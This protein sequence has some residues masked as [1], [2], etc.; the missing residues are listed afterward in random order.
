[1]CIAATAQAQDV[2][3]FEE[4]AVDDSACEQAVKP[5][6][7]VIVQLEVW[8]VT[9]ADADDETK[10]LSRQP[11]ED[12]DEVASRLKQLRQK[13][14]VSHSQYM[15]TT[16]LD[17]Q[18]TVL[19]LGTRQPRIQGTSVT[20]HGR[21][22]SIVYENVGALFQALTR[23]ENGSNVF[24]ELQVEESHMEPSDTIIHQPLEGDPTKIV[25]VKQF[26]H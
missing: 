26:V 17:G 9:L 19:Q 7:P 4:A 21:Q 16:V 11:F 20:P 13:G 2:D 23:V 6:G 22:N 8:L 12:G 14:V 24:A 1:L 25:E 18:K 5:T 10:K 15:M 3:V